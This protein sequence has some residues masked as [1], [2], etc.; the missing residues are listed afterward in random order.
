MNL[1]QQ[2]NGKITINSP[3]PPTLCAENDPIKISAADDEK[4][5]TDKVVDE[6]KCVSDS[7][8]NENSQAAMPVLCRERRSLSRSMS[9]SSMQI[10][11]SSSHR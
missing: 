8:S 1:F 10:S 9:R 6:A 4:K 5:T 3:A 7:D 2:T 11:D